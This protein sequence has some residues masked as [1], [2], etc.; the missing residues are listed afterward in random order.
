MTKQP[1][2]EYKN[3][4]CHARISGVPA[5]HIAGCFDCQ[6]NER[7]SAWMRKLSEQTSV[8]AQ[9]A[10]AGLV[11]FKARLIEKERAH[12]RASRP[13]IWV[14]GG[15]IVV[16]MIVMVWMLARTRMQFVPM[17][18]GIFQPL[19]TVD[20]FIVLGGISTILICLALSYFLLSTKAT[21][22]S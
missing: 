8:P 16:G 22:R 2:F 20:Q 3:K 6:E 17:V 13:I 5:E 14:Q 18:K 11:L 4:P 10:S 1:G 9:A 7:V 19:L 15:N 21:A 12:R